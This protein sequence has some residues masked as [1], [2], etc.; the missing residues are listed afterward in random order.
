MSRCF[1]RFCH[2]FCDL[3]SFFMHLFLCFV[4][5]RSFLLYTVSFPSYTLLIFITPF[6]F[7]CLNTYFGCFLSSYFL[8]MYTKR[9]FHPQKIILFA[10]RKLFLFLTILLPDKTCWDP[11][12]FLRQ[13]KLLFSKSNALHQKCHISCKGSHGLSAFSIS[14][15]LARSSSVNAVPV[16]AWCHRHAGDCEIFV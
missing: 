12:L 10:N 1:Y 9:A 8:L 5:F 7:T 4:H 6:V 13:S 15:C 2:I 16:L 3:F 14:L 11:L